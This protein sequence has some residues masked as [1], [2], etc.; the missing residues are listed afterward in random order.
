MPCGMPAAIIALSVLASVVVVLAFVRQLMRGFRRRGAS[1][2]EKRYRA[3]EVLLEQTLAQ[4][5]GEESRGVAQLRGSG[6]LALTASELWFV[7][8]VTNRELRIP[9]ADV[10]AVSLVRSHLGKTQFTDL[11]HVRYTSGGTEDAIAW[12]LPDP[13]VWKE[14]LESLR[15]GA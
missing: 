7:M 8:Y 10:R 12:R 5:F 11:L 4:S 1:A 13:K 15:A 6:A 14:K 9:I 2:I 3:G